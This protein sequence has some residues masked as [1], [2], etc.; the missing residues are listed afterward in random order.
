MLCGNVGN[1]YFC[2][3][4]CRFVKNHEIPNGCSLIILNPIPI[5]RDLPKTELSDSILLKLIALI[6]R[7]TISEFPN[8][9]F[10][11]KKYTA[12]R[13]ALKTIVKPHPTNAMF[14]KR[15]LL[16]LRLLTTAPNAPIATTSK[17]IKRLIRDP[18]NISPPHAAQAN[19]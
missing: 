14:I 13:N 2:V 10:T 7:S 4:N 11:P 12:I 6:I 17:A 8:D 5:E 19:M 16:I 9:I 1:P 15:F 3:S 18:D